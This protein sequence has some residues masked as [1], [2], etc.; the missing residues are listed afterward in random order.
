MND[1]RRR[2]AVAAEV[3]I[4]MTPAPTETPNENAPTGTGNPEDLDSTFVCADV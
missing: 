4:D 1:H 3:K 2:P